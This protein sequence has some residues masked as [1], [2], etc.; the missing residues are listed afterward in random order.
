MSIKVTPFK[1]WSHFRC[2]LMTLILFFFFSILFSTLY[3]TLKRFRNTLELSNNTPVIFRK[4]T[5]K[6]NVALVSF[7]TSDYHDIGSISTIN[8]L[9]YAYKHGYDM[10]VYQKPFYKKSIWIK[11]AWNKIPMVEAQLENYEWIIWIDSDAI[12]MRH[13][14]TLEDIIEI[15]KKADWRK[16][17][18]EI[19]L[20]ISYDINAGINSGIFFMRNTEWSRNVLKQ[21]QTSWKY[22]PYSLHW[23]AEQTPFAM[24]IKYGLDEH[25]RVTYKRVLNAYLKDYSEGTT[26]IM[27][28]AGCPKQKPKYCSG[29]MH[30]FYERWQRNNVTSV[31]DRELLRRAEKDFETLEKQ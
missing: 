20:I 3:L 17:D 10:I 9:F 24:E 5:I 11:P 16:K 2:F 7:Y 8:K 25:V 18:H 27:H 6:S 22:I 26:Y 15:S 30:E 12:I 21:V 1:R 19:D 23:Y 31:S 13:E 4:G 29:I 14:L 28:L